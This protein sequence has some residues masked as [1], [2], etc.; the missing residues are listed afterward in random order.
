MHSENE[1]QLKMGPSN[2]QALILKA[3]ETLAEMEHHL[4]E[5]LEGV[6][7]IPVFANLNIGLSPN[8]ATT[9][10]GVYRSDPMQSQKIQ[11][12]P[13]E[14]STRITMS[15]ARSNHFMASDDLGLV[16][17]LSVL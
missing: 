16:P 1:D 11:H 5:R 7:D 6:Q 14:T 10:S 9:A 3:L 13:V 12:M 15:R 4:P 17:L 2:K 8:Q